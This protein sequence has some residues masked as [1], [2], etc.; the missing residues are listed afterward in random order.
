M[1]EHA[2]YE[3]EALHNQWVAGRK[4]I[5]TGAVLRHTA[6]VP[7]RAIDYRTL[8]RLMVDRRK[9]QKALADAEAWGQYETSAFARTLRSAGWP[10]NVPP[11]QLRHTFGLALSEGGEDLSD[12]QVM[13]GHK[14]ITTTRRHYVP[15]LNSRLESA[16]R[17]VDGRFSWQSPLVPPAKP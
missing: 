12:I 8:N 5:S 4:N 3:P 16:A 14:H 15:V 2:F 6:P 10:A 9:T 11:Y 7:T 13:M 17:A 1:T